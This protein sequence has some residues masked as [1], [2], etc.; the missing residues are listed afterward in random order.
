MRALTNALMQTS[1]TID[2]AV[3]AACWVAYG[4]CVC[5]TAYLGLPFRAPWLTISLSLSVS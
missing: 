2:I 5:E 4:M 3:M 1:G